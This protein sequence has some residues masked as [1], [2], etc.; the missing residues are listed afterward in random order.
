MAVL[1][2]LGDPIFGFSLLSPLLLAE[3]FEVSESVAWVGAGAGT[4]AGAGSADLPLVVAS[5]A[6]LVSVVGWPVT[7]LG[8]DCHVSAP[9]AIEAGDEVCVPVSC[10]ALPPSSGLAT[11]C[12]RPVLVPTVVQSYLHS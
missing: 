7:L 8:S 12:Q 9:V 5:S 11:A 10:G 6:G 2:Q 3:A 1:N 4:G